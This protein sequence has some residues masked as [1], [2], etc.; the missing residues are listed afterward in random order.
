MGW[1][2]DGPQRLARADEAGHAPLRAVSARQRQGALDRV[3]ERVGG[4]REPDPVIL[5]AAA[6][7]DNLQE[8]NPCFL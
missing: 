1:S 8:A 6:L 2:A 3:D 5:C 4:D 7:V